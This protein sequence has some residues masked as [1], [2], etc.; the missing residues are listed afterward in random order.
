MENKLK[1]QVTLFRL[2]TVNNM[3]YD[4]RIYYFDES[5]FFPIP[6][7]PATPFTMLLLFN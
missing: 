3:I 7:N 5:E 6:K 1:G 4:K 2:S